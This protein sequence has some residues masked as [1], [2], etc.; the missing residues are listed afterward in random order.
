[1]RKM[2]VVV[3]AFAVALA[4]AGTSM[5]AEDGAKVYSSKGCSACHG[6]DAGGTKGLAPSLKDSKFVK[7]ADEAAIKAVIKDGRS[8]AK[9]QYKEFGSAMPANKLTDDELGALAKY[10]KGLK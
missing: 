8:G 9:K 4:F 5:A 10:L 6:K 3:M 1:M 2:I 7:T